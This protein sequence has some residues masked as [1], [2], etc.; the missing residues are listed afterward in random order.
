[1][2]VAEWSLVALVAAAVWLSLPACAVL[3][4]EPTGP[5]AG[6]P[7]RVDRPG[8]GRLLA[9]AGAGI[10]VVVVVGGPTGAA[11]GGLGAAALW[12]WLGRLES[13]GSIARR[14]RLQA[15]LPSAIGLLGCALD[16][17]ADPTTALATVGRALGDPFADEVARLQ[18]R[19]DLGA[20]RGEVW[21]GLA[22]HPQLGPLGRSLARSHDT[23]SSVAEAVHQLAEELEE[24][25]AAEVE[26]RARQLEVKVSLPLGACLLPAFVVLGVVPLVAGLLADV[27]VW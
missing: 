26:A 5:G 21:A 16:A 23:G 6:P 25:R 4:R 27:G 11:L 9:S 24:T 20:D 2:T 19:L 13:A 7:A 15:Q 10:G 8:R 18:H 12:W 17:G 14:E 1:M 3:R 22:A